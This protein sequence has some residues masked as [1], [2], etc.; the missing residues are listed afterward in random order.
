MSQITKCGD[1]RC[2]CHSERIRSAEG[3]G[4]PLSTARAATDAWLASVDFV[5][6]SL[7]TTGQ[8]KAIARILAA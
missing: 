7:D 4:I 6:E 1:R 5:L 8:T 3:P 2:S